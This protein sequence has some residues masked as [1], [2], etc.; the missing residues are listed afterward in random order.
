MSDVLPTPL[1]PRMI[2]LRRTFFLDAILILSVFV[3]VCR[4][5]SVFFVRGVLEITESSLEIDI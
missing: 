2:T 3:Y 1:S 4:G 5:S